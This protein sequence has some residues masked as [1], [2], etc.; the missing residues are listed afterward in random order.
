MPGSRKFIAKCRVCGFYVGVRM[1]KI[2]RHGWLD[3]DCKGSGTR[4]VSVTT[5][6]K[7]LKAKRKRKKAVSTGVDK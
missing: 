1:G 4:A 5:L 2:V 7:L 3:G 6:D